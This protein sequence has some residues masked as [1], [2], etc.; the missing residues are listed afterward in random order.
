MGI[1]EERWIKVNAED[2]ATHDGVVDDGGAKEW[3][4]RMIL[5]RTTR[6]QTMATLTIDRRGRFFTSQRSWTF[7]R[8]IRLSPLDRADDVATASPPSFDNDDGLYKPVSR[9]GEDGYLALQRP[10]TFDTDVDPT[11]DAA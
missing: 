3:D 6:R 10:E 5:P 4:M 1:A 9:A 7:P 8:K 2:I 11:F